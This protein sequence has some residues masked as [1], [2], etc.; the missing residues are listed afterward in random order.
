MDRYKGL[1]KVLLICLIA[2][3]FAFP[4]SADTKD[5]VESR[6]EQL[7]SEQKTLEAE[8]EQ[9]R[10]NKTDTESYLSDLDAKIEEFL[11]KM[12]EVTEKIKKTDDEIIETR[13][14][15]SQAR[16][17]EK[18]QYK[19][20]KARIKAIYESGDITY[21]QILF[22]GA[23]MRSLLNQ[24]EYMSMINIYDRNLLI[25]L[26]KTGDKIE[27]Y[28]ADLKANREVLEAQKEAYQLEKESLEKIAKERQ[29]ELDAA[30]SSIATLNYNI[31]NIQAK[32]DAQNAEMDRVLAEEK[33]A[34]EAAKRAEEEAA[35]ALKAQEEAASAAEAEQAAKE[36]EEAAKRA[37]EAEAAAAKAEE[38][39]LAQEEALR[40]AEEEAE[41]AKA[42]KEEAER[43]A[44]EEEARR[45]EEEAAAAAEE[46]EDDYSSGYS[47]TV[48]TAYAGRIDG[49][50]GEE[51]YYNQDL[52]DVI[53]RMR[54]MGFD[55]ESYPYWVRGDGCKMLGDYIICAANLDVHP[56]GST[57][58]SSL[59]TCLVCDT[60]G[61]A[62]YNIYQ[63]DIATTW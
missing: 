25:S 50:S 49:P 62:S 35:A 55:S 46:E 40:L 33:E 56:R 51:T 38:E 52:S 5:E 31:S 7:E 41:A 43:L 57:V 39:R 16:T 20:L 63:L 19:A 21:M 14:K 42:A 36:A 30:G 47:G 61:F 9:M 8:L 15:L 54:S 22:G 59:G 24:Q 2:V 1:L 4:V 32:I 11:E 10:K 45:A 23:D 37:E 3:C 17:D 53:S 58:E 34:E 44:A 26:Q 18:V 60:G 29:A 6:I 27:V 13:A 48:L 12:D 28:E